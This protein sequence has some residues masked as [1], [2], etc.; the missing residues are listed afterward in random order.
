M[1]A[2]LT[3]QS[4][5][6]TLNFPVPRPPSLCSSTHLVLLWRHEVDSWLWECWVVEGVTHS[7]H[8]HNLAGHR[9]GGLPRLKTLKNLQHSI[10][11]GGCVRG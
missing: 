11:V 2:L 8:Q 1:K 6:C 4:A 5:M 10:A 3:T 7:R 9:Q